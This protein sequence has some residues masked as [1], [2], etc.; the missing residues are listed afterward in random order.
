[1]FVPLAVASTFTS[2]TGM[3]LFWRVIMKRFRAR[4]P[5]AR[6]TLTVLEA[7]PVASGAIFLDHLVDAHARRD[8][9]VDVLLRVDVEVQDH[10]PV[11]LLGPPD[12]A[13]HV[14]ALAHRAPGQAVGRRELLVVRAC[15]GRLRVAA[16]VEELLPLADH[17]EVAVVQDGD[18]YVQPEV[19]DGG[20]FLDVH[21]E[22]AV[23]R[24]HPD[25]LV[26]VGESDA[27]RGG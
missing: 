5:G 16:V 27:H 13:L 26:R 9:G 3:R 6:R 8:H 2:A 14:V 17:A 7:T 19:A 15:Y 18:L 21:L 24:D 25:G 1:M 4:M 20:E 11:P 12:R 10:A 23:A 22:P